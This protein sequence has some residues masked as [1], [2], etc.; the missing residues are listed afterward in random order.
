MN[1]LIFGDSIAWGASDLEAGGWAERLKLSCL[2]GEVDINVYNLG[3]S[4]ENTNDLLK[5]FESEAMIREPGMIIFAIGINDSSLTKEGG[6]FV[7]VETFRKNI[8]ELIW[9][10][11]R[12]TEKIC[13]VGLTRVDESKT[14]PIPWKPEKY[15]TNESIEKFDDLLRALCE[16]KRLLYVKIGKAVKIRDLD[17]DGLHPNADGH[18]KIFEIVLKD[19]FSR[20]GLS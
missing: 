9:Q 8:L 20:Q 11:R 17:D 10:A 14:N 12:Y 4:G 16:Q 15:Y 2:R 1:I 3:I 18:K 19:V 7:D 6:N 5:R 13:F